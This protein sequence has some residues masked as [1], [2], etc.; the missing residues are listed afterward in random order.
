MT[1]ESDWLGDLAVPPRNV[2]GRA[3]SKDRP[4]RMRKVQCPDCATILYCT[5]VAAL[6]RGL[7]TCACGTPMIL[8]NLRD[9][10][11]V[12]WDAL[13]LELRSMSRA[14][15]NKAARELGLT[16]EPADLTRLGGSKGGA[17]Q[18]RCQ[19]DGGFCARYAS[20]SGY[21]REH[22]PG[23]SDRRYMERGA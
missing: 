19:W 12:E 8:P 9:R 15:Y 22:R 3:A 11:V 20:S 21:C 23:A 1:L 7:P 17:E 13:E 16:P 4:G 5:S 10:A 2:G 14:D 18:Q 6:E